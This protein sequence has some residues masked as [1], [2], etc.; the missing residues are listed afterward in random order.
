MFAPGEDIAIAVETIITMREC[1]KQ[2]KERV[3]F[4]LVF[5]LSHPPKYQDL[6]FYLR[7][8]SSHPRIC[9]S[10]MFPGNGGKANKTKNYD[11]HMV[12]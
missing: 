6:A 3:V 11:N 10:I 4:T 1:K 8:A 2:I 12:S 9:G 7:Q 5:A